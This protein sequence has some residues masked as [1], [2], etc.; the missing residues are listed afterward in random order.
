M[1]PFAKGFGTKVADPCGT[2]E[3]AIEAATRM[4]TCF[5]LCAPEGLDA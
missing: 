1:P 5:V 4:L 3:E 2:R